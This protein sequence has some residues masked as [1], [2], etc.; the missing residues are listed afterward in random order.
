[1][2][3]ASADYKFV[4]VD[5]G[6]FGSQSDGGIFKNTCFFRKLDKEEL[7]IPTATILPADP[8]GERLLYYFVGD[9]AFPPRTEIM[10]PY[11]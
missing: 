7:N 11:A 3:V 2:T 8:E 9:K 4:M 6:A 10:R 5:V 1:M